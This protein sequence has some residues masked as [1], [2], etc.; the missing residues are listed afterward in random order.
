MN[1]KYKILW[2]EDDEEVVDGKTG[3]TIRDFL[4][5]MGF[6]P[7]ITHR[8]NGEDLTNLLNDKN[9]DLIITDL[10]LGEHETG[11]ALIDQI[12]EGKIL[13]E[14]LLYSAI[15]ADLNAVLER[16]GWVE[17]ASFCV[18][19]S[20]LV[21][22]LKEIIS[23]T[24]RK[25]QD[26]NNARGLVIAETID[27]EK[28]I[29][30]ILLYYFDTDNELLIEEKT[31]LIKD[32]STKKIEKYQNDIA[33][34]QSVTFKQVRSLIEKDILTAGNSFAALHSLLKKKISNIANKLSA[35][36]I[37]TTLKSQLES[38][39]TDIRIAKK[40]LN[41]FSGEILKIRNTLAHVEE[42]LGE[43][44]FP[45]LKSI[46]TEG[47]IIRFNPEKYT[48]IRKN[49]RKHAENLDKILSHLEEV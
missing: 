30:S 42:E 18:G 10:N 4:A 1:L 19:V 38:K 25:Y 47:T 9:Y 13:T 31:K 34:L 45:F 44:G 32:I 48:E 26:V 43:D 22:K 23:L 36:N 15:A 35:G 12:R 14:V 20:N 5:E 40:E 24:V 3:A 17:R 27:L 37:D 33:E 7:V 39:L 2:F 29:E 16:K 49:L 8:F 41:N 11:E 46:N 6:L 21:G 28:K